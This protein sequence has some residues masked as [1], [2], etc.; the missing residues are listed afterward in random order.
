MEVVDLEHLEEQEIFWLATL[1]PN[2]VQ[3]RALRD[4]HIYRREM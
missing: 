1:K 2:E 3:G 4:P